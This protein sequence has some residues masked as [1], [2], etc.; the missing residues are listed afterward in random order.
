MA[1]CI[2]SIY[3]S[4][5][6]MNQVNQFILIIGLVI[7]LLGIFSRQIQKSI[8]SEP[9]I[10]LGIGVLLGPVLPI[11]N[12][13]EGGMQKEIVIEQA[14]RFALAIGLMATAM[15]IPLTQLRRL[16][17][18]LTL[19]LTLVMIGM[20]VVST[21]I[22]H[23]VF[24]LPLYLSLLIGAIIT[25]TDPILATSIVS[26]D[27]AKQNV[28]EQ[29]RALLSAESGFND[30]LAYAF[31][32]LPLL[33]MKFPTGEAFSEWFSNIILWEVGLA[34]IFAL[35]TGFTAGKLLNWSERHREIREEYLFAYTIALSIVALTG[36]KLLH[37]DGILAVFIAGV[38]FSSVYRSHEKAEE[39]VIQE[40]V[41]RFFFIPAFLLLGI[42]IPWEQWLNLEWQ[43]VLVSIL[44]IFLRRMPIVYI[45]KNV[46]GPL[47]KR[48]NALF[49][50]W[51][52][53]IG[54]SALFYAMLAEKQAQNDLIWP[55]TSFII[56]I[57]TII[58]G[59]TAVPFTRYY[60]NHAH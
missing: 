34:V 8:V 53:P 48:A 59:I 26:G 23:V 17:L 41:N 51:F 12:V 45:L 35:F 7:L 5:K 47:R 11:F 24:Q 46:L 2:L 14:S 44:I 57:S 54:I 25:P 22:I 29:L 21:A 19:M 40:A 20:W 60:K 15:R 39:E 27:I 1:S 4:G 32:F 6:K 55:L 56:V 28:P 36:A 43:L 9:M 52:G 31:V 58:F 33:L 50:G 37:T 18:P 10:A 13:E 49:I 30:G 3:L 38:T 16:A 42:F